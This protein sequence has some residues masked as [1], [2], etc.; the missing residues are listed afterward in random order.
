MSPL[1]TPFALRKAQLANRIV[2]SP[3]LQHA[4]RDG[5]PS[6]WHLMHYGTLALSGAGLLIIEGTAVEPRG[7]CGAQCIGLYSDAAEAAIAG[8]VAFV[9]EH[10]DIRLGIQLAHAGRKGAATPTWVPRRRLTAEEG[11]WQTVGCSPTEDPVFGVPEV[12]DGRGI[13]DIV[14]AWAG[15]AR[16]AERAGL[17]LLELHFAHGYLVHQFLSPLTNQ[18]TDGYGGSLERRMRFAIDVF[19]ACRDAWPDGKPIGVRVSATDWVP[20]G[21]TVEET[22]ELARALQREGCDY[23]CA[24]SGG[25]SLAQQIVAGPGYQVAFAERI[26]TEAGIPTIAVGQ[27]T[28]PRQAEQIVANGQADLVALARRMLYDPRWPWHAAVELGVDLQYPPRYRMC[29]PRMGAKLTLPES[30]E[31]GERLARLQT[32]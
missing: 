26:R 27:I 14:D 20:G 4:A 28:E 10:A 15:A 25:A 12:L 6:K 17:D 23:I 29:H 13:G 30:R 3:M 16:R 9:R 5:V 11:G 18:R 1:F 24:S 2:V 32:S 21:W 7:R 19:R 8:I 31:H 22:V